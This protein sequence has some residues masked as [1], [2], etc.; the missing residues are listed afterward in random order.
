[1]T[2]DVELSSSGLSVGVVGYG[3]RLG[4]IRTPDRHDHWADVAMGFDD[5]TAWRTDTTYQ[6]ATIGRYANRIDRGSFT[7]DG[8]TYSVPLNHGSTALHGG[9]AGF[10]THQWE[11]EPVITTEHDMSVTLRR[12]SPDG[13]MGFPGNLDVSAVFSVS[14]TDLTIDYRAITDAPTAVNLTNHVYLNLSGRPGSVA[15]HEMTVFADRYA[16]VNAAFIP[17]GDIL[18]LTEHRWTTGGRR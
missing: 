16:A 13:E 17:T 15:D 14:G 3:A 2:V 1:M 11:I 4:Y 18:E 8:R 5:P 12:T 6:G 10:D 9:P 7:L